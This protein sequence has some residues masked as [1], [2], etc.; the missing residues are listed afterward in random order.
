MTGTRKP[1]NPQTYKPVVRTYQARDNEAVWRLHLEGVTAT[2][3]SVDVDPKYDADLRNIESDYLSEGSCFWVGEVD[4]E[5]IAMAAVQRIDARTGRLRRMR[6]TATWRRRGVATMLLKVAE[7]FCRE[8]GYSRL[9]LDTTEQQTAA[10]K[11]YE[12]AGFA[13]AGSRMMGQF[14]V[15]DYLKDLS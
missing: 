12:N 3:E 7:N 11:L 14:R 15:Y 13:R 5:P 6:V 1:T 2:R 10:H 9:I 4:G 8:Q